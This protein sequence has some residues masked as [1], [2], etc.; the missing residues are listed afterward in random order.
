[1]RDL[2]S[3]P[4][5]AELIQKEMDGVL[6]DA[7]FLR[8]QGILKADPEAVDYYVKTVLA[9]SLLASPSPV[10]FMEGEAGSLADS[11]S[12]S[13]LWKALA[14][15][16][17]LAPTVVPEVAE[18]PAS[19]KLIAK[20]E[21]ETTLR[22]VNKTSFLI[23]AIST[24]ALICLIAYVQTAPRLVR[25]PVA[26]LTD[27][28]NAAF[29]GG[30]SYRAGSRL[31]N[32]KES[33]RLERGMIEV[34]FDYGAKVVIEAPAE[35]RM[36]SAEKMV[37]QAG[38]L[39]ARVPGSAKGFMVDT[40]GSS[41]IDLGTEFGIHVDAD[42]TTD[43]H[44]F[45]GKASLISGTKGQTKESEELTAGQA[46]RVD[47]SGLVREIRKA[48]SLFVRSFDSE[49]RFVWKGQSLD[50]SDVV[51]GGNG[52]G[53]GQL[54]RGVNPLAGSVEMLTEVTASIRGPAA[55]QPVKDNPL[56]DGVFVP[57]SG[58]APVQVSSAG[59]LFENCPQTNGEFWG[60]VINGA[61]HE[62][63]VVKIPRH[64]LRLDG[65][66][67]GKAEA[68]SI[69][70]H[71]NQG[72]TFDLEAIR[73]QTGVGA[74]SFTARCGIS[75]SLHDYAGQLRAWQGGWHEIKPEDSRADFYVLVDGEVRFAAR[76]VSILDKGIPVRVVLSAKD[77]FLTLAAT[78][79]T[80]PWKNTNDW[81]LFAEPRLVLHE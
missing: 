73:R 50:L 35:F 22:R 59:H 3:Q 70:M 4:E 81:T 23:A 6:T 38:R 60:G 17:K 26:T 21:Y 51:G 67:Y 42:G 71:A 28:L 18:Q 68:S 37:L 44:M 78:Q 41:V 49:S 32:G 53:T 77:R 20:V 43:V 27:S 40:P 54:N 55:Y 76:D 10:S 34:E 24:A 11:P 45:E 66:A 36:E 69:Y 75:E 61:W 52:F 31:Y 14:E 74:A 16:E 29:A 2:K 79:G 48:E 1:M 62:A 12:D 46:R 80:D 33:L 5:L 39:Y 72:I 13:A 58:T 19:Q 7:E 56:I 47:P 9:I 63:E 57:G 25:E 15:E 8:L 64:T 65:K 30:E